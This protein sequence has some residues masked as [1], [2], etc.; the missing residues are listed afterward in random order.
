M[1]AGCGRQGAG[2]GHGLGKVS[3]QQPLAVEGRDRQVEG[4]FKKG[5][6]LHWVLY[7][8][9]GWLYCFN[10]KNVYYYISHIDLEVLAAIVSEVLDPS[11]I[12]D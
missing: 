11:R 9:S 6:V 4:A 1:P 8:A 2:A 7:S 3:G 12:K 5:N 10:E